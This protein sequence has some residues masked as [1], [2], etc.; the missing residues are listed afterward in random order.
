M[1]NTGNERLSPSRWSREQLASAEM[2]AEG[3]R[4]H[5]ARPE[6]SFDQYYTDD[7][8]NRLL[9][10]ADGQ[11]VASEHW[12]DLHQLDY[13][14]RRGT[15]SDRQV[16]YT[17]ALIMDSVIPVDL[18]SNESI[19]KSARY[20]RSMQEGVHQRHK[21]GNPDVYRDA[22]EAYVAKLL[23]E[24]RGY[25]DGD[26]LKKFDDARRSCAL[27]CTPSRRLFNVATA[28]KRVAL[29]AA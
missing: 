14:L 19:A 5:F 12:H 21:L 1:S 9:P 24:A 13:S 26:S 27:M 11:R 2:I 23:T 25:L 17:F 29:T 8:L 18:A 20:M 16:V 10:V 28:V 6:L 3:L 22:S 4:T 7:E 15:T